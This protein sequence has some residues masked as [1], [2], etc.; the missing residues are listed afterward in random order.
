MSGQVDRRS[1]YDARRWDRPQATGMETWP[2]ERVQRVK[3]ETRSHHM[4]ILADRELTLRGDMIG[5]CSKCRAR[6]GC[7]CSAREWLGPSADDHLPLTPS[8]EGQGA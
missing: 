8:T 5:R 6:G 2:L 3:A 4:H 1:P 7:G